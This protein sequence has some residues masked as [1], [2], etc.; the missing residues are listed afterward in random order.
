VP[1]VTGAAYGRPGGEGK[2]PGPCEGR[3]PAAH[4]GRFSNERRV[5]G[6]VTH[7]CRQVVHT[8]IAGTIVEV[9]SRVPGSTDN[10]LD[11]HRT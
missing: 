8:S 4:I 3:H 2:R 10:R 1:V 6:R 7:S 11:E 5:A 9:S